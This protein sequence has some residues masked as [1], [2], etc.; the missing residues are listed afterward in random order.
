MPTTEKKVIRDNMY[1]ILDNNE[2]IA[3]FAAPMAV[4]DNTPSFGG[5]SLSLKRTVERRPA[6]RWEIETNLAPLSYDAQNLFAVLIVKGYGSKIDIRVPQNFG[7]KRARTA[8]GSITATGSGSSSAI[9]V[10]GVSG[11]IPRGTFIKFANH[12]KVYMLTAD[13]NSSGVGSVYPVLRQSVT[14]AVSYQDDVN[15]EFY[16][17]L[18]NVRGMSYID[19]ILMDLGRLRFVEAV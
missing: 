15:G 9:S 2:V 10:Q 16:A 8:T 14:G 6:Q 18:D 12:T 5:D 11:V 13:L 19:G 1:G 17:D 4:I 7:A 3:Q